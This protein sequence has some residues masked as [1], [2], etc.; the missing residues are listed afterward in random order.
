MLESGLM[1]DLHQCAIS[2]TGQLLCIY[3]DLVYHLR[4]NLQTPFR[5]MPLTPLMQEYN[6]SISKARI[7]VE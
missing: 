5:H 3:D 7:A 4:I 2:S 6:K 1:K